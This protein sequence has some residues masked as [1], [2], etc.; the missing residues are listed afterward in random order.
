MRLF[1]ALDIDPAIRERL[2]RLRADLR[3]LAPAARWVGV[4]NFH[5]TL[6][7]IGEVVPAR[8]E[9]MG[10]A[11]ATVEA[12]P[13][14]LALRGTGFFPNVKAARVFWVGIEGGKPLVE[15]A[16]QV[17]RALA[18]VG[19]AREEKPY[20]PHLTLARAGEARRP[21]GRPG[22]MASDRANSVF[23]A[24]QQRLA[25]QAAEFG[26]MRAQRFHLFESKLLPS[27]AQYAKV[28]SYE[29]ISPP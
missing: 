12:A 15:L 10:Q 21:S 4:E 7:F 2:A 24:I 14:E 5:V 23:A 27:G 9:Q 26:T 28:G 8:L 22:M 3:P 20:A 29:L 19:V 17:D 16:G 1:V 13:V 11:L 18:A 6:K 25:Q